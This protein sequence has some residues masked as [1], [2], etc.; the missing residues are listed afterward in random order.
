MVT[1][2]DTPHFIQEHKPTA[3]FGNEEEFGKYLKGE[4]DPDS[5]P[6]ETDG[7]NILVQRR[8]DLTH[9]QILK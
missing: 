1:D 5:A 9:K 8:R 7:G 2:E 3:C 4:E 6:L